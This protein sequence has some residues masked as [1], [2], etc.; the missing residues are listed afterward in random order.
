[1]THYELMI[2]IST[3]LT[4][5]LFCLGIT[6]VL[7]KVIWDVLNRRIDEISKAVDMA[8][9]DIHEIKYNYLNR[10]DDMKTHVN[11]IKEEIIEKINSLTK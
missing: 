5:L 11:A 10:F 3:F 7:V 6:G 4:V 1:M 8:K 2:S 9:S